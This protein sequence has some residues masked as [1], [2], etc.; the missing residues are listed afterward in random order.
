M[1]L[2]MT[3]KPTV[4]ARRRYASPGASENRNREPLNQRSNMNFSIITLNRRPGNISKLAGLFVLVLACTFGARTAQAAG[5]VVGKF[6]PREKDQTKPI[7]VL[8]SKAAS[9]DKAI[10]CKQL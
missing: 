6:A 2:Y 1:N 4:C 10:A 9:E 5:D 7:A 3:R 8:K